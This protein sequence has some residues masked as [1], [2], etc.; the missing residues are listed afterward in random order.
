MLRAHRSRDVLALL[1]REDE[2]TKVGVDRLIV[3]EQARVLRE[4]IDLLAEDAPRLAVQRVAVRGRL[5][6]RA[7]FVDCGVC[8]RARESIKRCVGSV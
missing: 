2:P 5:G 7:S 8:K 6:V 1:L 4:N 3:V